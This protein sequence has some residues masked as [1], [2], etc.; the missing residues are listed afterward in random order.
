L[1]LLTFQYQKARGKEPM[2]DDT[3]T[4]PA[5]LIDNKAEAELAN[6]PREL[7]AICRSLRAKMQAKAAT[8]GALARKPEPQ[9]PAKVIQLDFWED[10]RRAA[11]NRCASR[12]AAV[13]YGSVLHAKLTP[14][15]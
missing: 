15:F 12:I 9:L 13:L 1:G 4:T 5:A 6:M 11:P 14:P 7:A 10:G 3:S 2:P 8:A